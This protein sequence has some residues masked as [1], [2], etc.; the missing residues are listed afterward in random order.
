MFNLNLHISKNIFEG[1]EIPIELK[2]SE[3]ITFAE[4]AKKKFSMIPQLKGIYIFHVGELDKIGKVENNIKH[5]IFYIGAACRQTLRTRIRNRI[6]PLSGKAKEDSLMKK[7]AAQYDFDL[8]KFNV[9]FV[10]LEDTTPFYIA[11]LLEG[12]LF[13]MYLEKFNRLPFCNTALR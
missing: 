9:T 6:K 10:Q 5:E 13:S 2:I 4:G 7:F 11:F 8:T 3:T 12:Y 1:I